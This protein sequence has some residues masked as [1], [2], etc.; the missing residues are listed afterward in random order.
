MVKKKLKLKPFILLFILSLAKKKLQ[1]IAAKQAKLQAAK[2]M[3]QPP[4]GGTNTQLFC[5]CCFV[6]KEF[7]V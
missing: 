3:Q 1:A 4:P 5:C 7:T 6:R 2:I